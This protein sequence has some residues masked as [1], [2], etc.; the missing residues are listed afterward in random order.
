MKNN[1]K[2]LVLDINLGLQNL[3]IINPGIWFD[4]IKFL[5][6]FQSLS[7]VFESDKDFN[8][9][10]GKFMNMNLVKTFSFEFKNFNDY[11]LLE[12]VSNFI[13]LQKI[14]LNLK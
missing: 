2:N 1:D 11:N 12:R 5:E 14:S 4:K 3:K 8:L 13:N 10:E 6:E 9:Y 7:V